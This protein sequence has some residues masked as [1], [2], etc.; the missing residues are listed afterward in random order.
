MKID[1]S[2]KA[3]HN[4]SISD[5]SYELTSVRT[6]YRYLILLGV[7]I[8]LLGISAW[9]FL[10]TV[11]ETVKG[12]GIVLLKGGVSKVVSFGSGRLDELSIKEG[13]AVKED[14]VIGLINNPE[15]SLNLSRI[16][17]EYKS[18]QIDD[19]TLKDALDTYN[20]QFG[21]ISEK[22]T[23][24]LNEIRQMLELRKKHDKEMKDLSKNLVKVGT[25][26]KL[27]YYRLYDQVISS[28]TSIQNLFIQLLENEEKIR[29]QDWETQQ[30]LVSIKQQ[31]VNKQ[32][33]LEAARS[34]FNESTVLR[35]HHK[36]TV[37]EILKKENDFVNIGDVVALVA[38]RSKGVYFSG[39]LPPEEG[40]RVK[41][42]MQA[43][44]SPFIAPASKYGY[45]KCVVKKVGLAP[46]NEETVMAELSNAALSAAL[47]AHKAVLKIEI[48]PLE[49]S[50]TVSGY[51]WTSKKGSP[52][53]IE[54][55]VTGTVIVDVE[56]RSPISYVI[57]AL[58]EMFSDK[59]S[60]YS[61]DKQ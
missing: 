3:L 28:E 53:R 29:M 8:L 39:Y 54:N 30:K 22:R 7:T 15:Q 13:D 10:G 61:P 19:K 56:S 44:F 16:E 17:S 2:K 52:D 4:A 36:G 1:Y 46:V 59:T 6:G 49:D 55:G 24:T 14:E 18:L 32:H 50:S 48:E 42:G 45:I 60:L 34:V 40:K 38:D 35:T 12:T 9:G 23:I 11:S 26:S 21:R 41:E 47:T 33:E 20:S 25:V 5:I 37:V 57:P 27:E 51:A 43:Y 58:Y 31:L